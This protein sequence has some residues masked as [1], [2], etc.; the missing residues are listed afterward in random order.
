MTLCIGDSI[1]LGM[2]GYSYIPFADK[3]QQ[4]V[5][6]GVNGE[7]LLGGVRRLRRYMRKRAYREADTVIFSLGTNDIL[8]PYLGNRSRF[9]QIQYRLRNIIRRFSSDIG[10]FA[11][12]YEEAVR[13]MKHN[14]YK[15]VL[16]GLP[17]I[18]LADYPLG[19]VEAYNS[20]IRSVARTYDAEFID[21]YEM[22]KKRVHRDRTCSWGK[23]NAGRIADGLYMLLFPR[24]KDSLS[25]RRGL[26]VTVDG[27][28]FNSRSARMLAEAVGRAMERAGVKTV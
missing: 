17:Y 12:Y 18:Q 16:V 19:K 9:W 14:G 20:C 5:N 15:V 7:S 11:G 8:L 24:R 22:Q 4:L 28:H 21:I 10:E 26:D 3:K 23:L 2:M 1:T 25:R 13:Q 27:V 6:L